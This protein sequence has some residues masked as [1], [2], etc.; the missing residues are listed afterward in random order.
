MIIYADLYAL[1]NFI[2]D[3]FCLF[4]T[5]AVLHRKAAHLRYLAASTLGVVYSLLGA[6]LIR[7]EPIAAI[8]VSLVM[9]AIAFWSKNF[10]LYIKSVLVF[11]AVAMLLGGAV[12]IFYRFVFRLKDTFL[13][14]NGL[15]V[16][17]FI[18]LFLILFIVIYTVSRLV[19]KGVYTKTV[20]VSIRLKDRIRTL[21]LLVDT[22]NLLKDPFTGLDVIVVRKESISPLF[23]HGFMPFGDET[24]ISEIPMHLVPVQTVSGSSLLTAFTPDSLC[25]ISPKGKSIPFHASVA[26]KTESTPNDFGG[27]DGVIGYAACCHIL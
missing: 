27:A 20:E 18:A 5:G 25:T 26:V 7:F 11:Y 6:Y 12:T 4:A 16:G 8:L 9:C 15:T 14:R 21:H 23:V 10:F 1:V 24:R 13:F 22:G 17:H 3:Y 2:M 19:S